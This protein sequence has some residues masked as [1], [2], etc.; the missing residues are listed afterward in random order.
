MEKI[1]NGLLCG[2]TDAALPKDAKHTCC[3]KVLKMLKRINKIY[4]LPIKTVCSR[5]T[6]NLHV[7][8][9]ICKTWGVLEMQGRSDMNERHQHQLYSPVPVNNS[10]SLPLR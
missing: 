6:V 4:I 1:T 2:K 10:F 5:L 8:W 3:T 9:Q 7:T